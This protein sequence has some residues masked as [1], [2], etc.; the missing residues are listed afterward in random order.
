[1]GV[2][3]F[4][5]KTQND[6][7]AADPVQTSSTTQ[8]Q[9]PIQTTTAPAANDVQASYG[10]FFSSSKP[11]ANVTYPLP[12]AGATL[13]PNY[14]AGVQSTT[15]APTDDKEEKDKLDITTDAF[16]PK[17]DVKPMGTDPL[18][19]ATP[20][21]EIEHE[22]KEN[23]S[24][25]ID[26]KTDALDLTSNSALD[27]SAP[28]PAV[29]D[30][31]SKQLE[32]TTPVSTEEL[33]AQL[34]APVASTPA[35]EPKVE[36][37]PETVPGSESGND[38][39]T[40]NTTNT[41]DFNPPLDALVFNSG[42]SAQGDWNPQ[43]AFMSASNE[44]ISNEPEATPSI[45]LLPTATV[46]S[47]EPAPVIPTEVAIPETVQITGEEKSVDW[48]KDIE[49][50][51]P[52]ENTDTK[53]DTA[54]EESP[55]T[56][57]PLVTEYKEASKEVDEIP[58]WMKEFE[59]MQFDAKSQE[60][61]DK[62]PVDLVTELP[63][64]VIAD[65]KKKSKSE[66]KVE[67]KELVSDLK[68]SN[69]TP[70]KKV[71]AY[72]ES[73]EPQTETLQLKYFRD[74][75]LV[76]LNSDSTDTAY[77]NL[78][79]SLVNALKTSAARLIIDSSQGHGKAVL[80]SLKDTGNLEVNGAYLRPYFSAYSDEPN[81]EVV[82]VKNYTETLF[83]NFVERLRYLYTSS[84]LFIVLD[85][86]GL[87]NLADISFLL[88]MQKMYYGK[89]KPV[90]LFGSGWKNKMETLNNMLNDDEKDKVY[91]VKDV[92]ELASVLKEIEE[93]YTKSNY[94]STKRVTDLRDIEDEKQF[95]I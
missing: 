40:P 25:P 2:F 19:S 7:D 37:E 38:T 80:E 71:D 64:E 62:A 29:T 90:I 68:L 63:V 67:T 31:I 93:G 42:T 58:E 13:T 91:V 17:A 84:E 52:F 65:K 27:F 11:A 56:A 3:D 73:T 89:H 85:S 48:L 12:A 53:Q 43:N 55:V 33:K 51:A 75:A 41:D 15:T 35:V 8:T 18:L 72:V 83:S 21:V 76:G 66:D 6:D 74:V 69:D 14:G 26:S 79:K 81:G 36:L 44:G 57:T 70:E 22:V 32:T 78:V 60:K 47:S 28:I 16:L 92:N 50:S 5:K 95:M 86:K 88:A 46:A 20:S 34:E 23:N 1:M 61:S 94:Y 59:A 49:I 10:S 4:L 82:D 87:V 30:D 9:D 77:I 54:A 45:D 39:E 24:L